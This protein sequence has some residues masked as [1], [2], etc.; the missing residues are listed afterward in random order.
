ML[1]REGLKKKRGKVWSF[2]TPGTG[3]RVPRFPLVCDYGPPVYKLYEKTD[4]MVEEVF[5]KR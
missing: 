2:T 1:I 3:N 4:K 5:P